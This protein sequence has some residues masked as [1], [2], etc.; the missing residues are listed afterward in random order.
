M[1]VEEPGPVLR[2]Q[3]QAKKMNTVVTPTKK[4][5]G[6]KLAVISPHQLP[7]KSEGSNADITQS[8]PMTAGSTML[9]FKRCIF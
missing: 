1:Q 3:L 8:L 7:N 4:V 2:F 5:R 9:Y 6:T